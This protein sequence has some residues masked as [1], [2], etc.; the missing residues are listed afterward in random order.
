MVVAIIRPDNFTDASGH[1]IIHGTTASELL[2]NALEAY[3]ITLPADVEARLWRHPMGMTNRRPLSDDEP[4]E[5][6]ATLY[7]RLRR[8]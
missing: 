4:P 2:Q 3:E 1:R 5:D 6:A 8:V 7:L